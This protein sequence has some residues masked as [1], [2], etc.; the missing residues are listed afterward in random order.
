MSN[1]KATFL[2]TDMDLAPSYN[3]EAY[4]CE[5]KTEK[6]ALAKAK[7]MLAAGSDDEVW[8]WRLSHIVSRPDIEPDIERV[9]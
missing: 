1:I 2:V 4:Y 7:E 5:H 8:V 3:E 6:A 9:P